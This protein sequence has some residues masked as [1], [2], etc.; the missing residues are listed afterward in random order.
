MVYVLYNSFS[1][2]HY[3][4]DKLKEKMKDFFPGEKLSFT[5][6]IGQKLGDVWEAFI[7]GCAYVAF[8]LIQHN[9]NE[10][11]IL[12]PSTKVKDRGNFGIDVS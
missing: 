2:A 5:Q 4:E 7:I 9:V 10:L 6:L 8:G 1:G 11:V 12:D 3:G